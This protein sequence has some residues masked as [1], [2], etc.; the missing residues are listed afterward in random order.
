M[1]SLSTRHLAYLEVFLGSLCFGFLG[2]FAKLAYSRS[3]TVGEL[4]SFRFLAAAILLMSFMFLFKP[5]WLKI[6]WKQVGISA[7][8]GIFGYACFGSLYFI[9]IQ[10]MSIS[11]AAILLFTYPF[12]VSLIGHFFLSKK[13][14][15]F[16]W[17]LLAVAILG[18]I[19]LIFTEWQIG[20][21]K[22]FLAG[23]GSAV[24]YAIYV[25]VSARLQNKIRP[26]SS[27]AY[28][29]FFA[30][31]GLFIFHQPS[32]NR[33]FEFA[34]QDWAI[35]LGIAFV[36]TIAPMTLILSSLQKIPESQTALLSMVEP[37]TASLASVFIFSES[38]EPRQIIGA[39]LIITA[40]ILR[41]KSN[42]QTPNSQQ[43]SMTN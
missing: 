6:G 8:L 40:L 9:A 18:M 15:G 7:C 1:K 10:G 21:P 24:F 4:L 42:I 19:L 39:S 34:W 12:W 38:L 30:G 14:S 36:C 11:T 26:L 32:L 28:V 35:L 20:S 16:D 13:L 3:I 23:I 41:I 27:S 2:V 29:I 31:V 22:Y 37:L 25:L 43:Q 17:G 5:T 33:L